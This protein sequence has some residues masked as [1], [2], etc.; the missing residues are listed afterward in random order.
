MLYYRLGPSQ[1]GCLPGLDGVTVRIS[2][3]CRK[4]VIF[5]GVPAPP[6]GEIAYGGT[7]CLVGLTQGGIPFPY[8]VTARHVATK[9]ARDPAFVIRV[10]NK[11]GGSEAPEG[12]ALEWCYHPDP[13]VDLAAA[14]C[15]LDNRFFDHIYVD[16][17]QAISR[18]T[19]EAGDPISIVGLFRLHAGSMRNMPIV[20]TG[21]IAALSDPAE[22]IPLRDRTTGQVVRADAY[23]VEAQ[24]L[25][26]LSGS[27]VFLHQTVTLPVEP[28]CL[29][30]GPVQLVGLFVG[31]WDGEPGEILAADRNLR[32][33]LRVPVG[34]GIVVPSEKIV[35]L[36]VGHPKLKSEREKRTKDNLSRRAGV[37]DDAFPSPQSDDDANPNHLADFRRLVDVAARKRPQ[38]DQT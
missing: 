23:L 16:I 26:G 37:T 17:S 28:K 22:R 1:T 13:T 36:I 2:A 18:A 33:G 8:V 25:E 32:G 14:Y 21:H 31:S 3:D 11:T 24:T 34:M 10:N 12:A 19:V 20:H 35:E 6:D 9:L 29:A 4:S 5:F 7:G 27:P 30:Y 38:G 15:S